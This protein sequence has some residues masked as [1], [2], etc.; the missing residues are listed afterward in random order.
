MSILALTDFTGK[1][2]ITKTHGNSSTIQAFIDEH[3]PVILAEMLGVDMADELIE[4]LDELPLTPELDKIYEPLMFNDAFGRL[5]TSQGLKKLLIQ[6][7]YATY[8][9]ENRSIP[10]TNGMV[11]ATNEG[12]K[13]AVSSIESVINVYN[14]SI[15]SAKTIQKYICMNLEDYP[16]YKG[17]SKLFSQLI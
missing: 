14:D 5:F 15:R 17:G 12:G 16:N 3:E 13:L 6:R 2:A 7:I 11:D 10:T 9:Y 1:Y 8:Y 4:N